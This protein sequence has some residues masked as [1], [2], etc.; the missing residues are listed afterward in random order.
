MLLVILI[1]ASLN[2]FTQTRS[3]SIVTTDETISF[4]LDENAKAR[5]IIAAQE[6]RI[7]DLEAQTAA[8]KENSDSIERSYNLA[9]SEIDSLRRANDA[10]SRA[11]TLNEQTIALISSDRDKWKT[12]AKKQKKG[13]Y[14]AYLIAAGA[15]A[16][17]LL[18]P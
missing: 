1:A 17:K 11:V 16:L 8:E 5:E 9:K 13:K 3:S 12:E 2:V 14:K 4:L 7:T 10:L 6:K 18:I 15:I